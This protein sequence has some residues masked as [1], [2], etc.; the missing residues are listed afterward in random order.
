MPS[1]APSRRDSSGTPVFDP[2]P[3]LAAENPK[4]AALRDIYA[5]TPSLIEVNATPVNVYV[6]LIGDDATLT[7]ADATPT[8][9]NASPSLIDVLTAP[10]E[11][12]RMGE[13]DC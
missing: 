13:T 1:I 6:A 4:F 5:S 7:D 8:D 3:P 11:G 9:A 10:P 12:F 2:L